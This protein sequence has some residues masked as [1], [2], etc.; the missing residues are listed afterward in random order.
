MSRVSVPAWAGVAALCVLACGTGAAPPVP[1]AAVS[2]TTVFPRQWLGAELLND[3][4]IEAL[5]QGSCVSGSLCP[6]VST[7]Q[8]PPTG[9]GYQQIDTLFTRNPSHIDLYYPDCSSTTACARTRSWW[10]VE[11]PEGCA[12]AGK[13]DVE[14]IGIDEYPTGSEGMETALDALKG[15][16]W[17]DVAP[18]PE[19]LAVPIPAAAKARGVQ[20]A[21][22]VI[23]LACF[24][25]CKPSVLCTDETGR[26]GGG[27]GALG[28]RRC[29][30]AEGAIQQ[31]FARQ[32][33]EKYLVTARIVAACDTEGTETTENSFE[34]QRVSLFIPLPTSTTDGP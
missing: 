30:K 1:E 22:S 23:L 11:A 20:K 2:P 25:S 21:D 3:S 15:A 33:P 5:I 7:S 13:E 19:W 17:F 8:P 6:T 9:L 27:Q 29:D 12:T 31:W 10:G 4:I 34:H 26:T 32:F 24:E 18:P 28:H 14:A 16:G